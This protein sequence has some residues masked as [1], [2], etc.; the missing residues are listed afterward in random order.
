MSSLGYGLVTVPLQATVTVQ[1]E[2][3]RGFG[4]LGI[5]LFY[6]LAAVA[7][8]LFL[9][10]VFKQY[11]KYR[12][13]K[14]AAGR[15]S[16]LVPRLVGAL[17]TIASHATVRRT[18]GYAGFAH[19]LVFWGFVALLIGTA[20]VG[21]D[22]DAVQLAL[23]PDA[24]L[25]TGNVYLVFSSVM[26]LAG[27]AFIVGLVMM[28]VRRAGFG[29][30]KLDYA[31]VDLPEGAYD[32]S[33]Y[34]KGDALFL[35]LL[36]GIAITG[37]LIE[38]ARIA[39]DGPEFEV[40]SFVGWGI[41]QVGRSL[42]ASDAVFDAMWWVHVAAVFGFIAYLPHSKA[43]HMITD[44]ASLASTDEAA[45]IA[46]PKVEDVASP[47]VAAM[48]DFS[49]RQLLSFDACT[50]CG[51]CHEVCPARTSGAPL[52]P[53]DLILDLREKASRDFGVKEIFGISRPDE[54]EG[55]VAGGFIS[56][57]TLWSCTTCRACTD[58]CPV[59]VEHVVDIVQMR[60]SLIDKGAIPDSLGETL[61]S[62]D[63]K[64]NSFG[65]SGRKRPKW[66]KPLDFKVKDASKDEVDVLWFVGD[67]ASYNER[68]QD[69]TRSFAQVLENAGVDFGTL[70]KAEKS[71]GNDVRRV[72][73]EGLF[74]A[75][76]S[77]NIAALEKATFK[78]IVTTDPHTLN[79]LKH[80]YPAL[81][82]D[83]EVLHYSE[84]LLELIEAKKIELE[85]KTRRV[86][87][88]DP[89]YLGRYGGIFEVPRQVLEACG[90][91][92]VEMPRNREESFC[93]GAGG[94]R[95][96]MPDAES[97]KERPA[98][99]RIREAVELGVDTFVVACPKD[100]VMFSDA[101]KT[102]GNEG[103]IV[104]RDLIE[105]VAESAASPEKSEEKSDG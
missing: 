33:S 74:E 26:D 83:Y 60:R 14:D 18:D 93:C 68:C 89:C 72:G 59:G 99:N 64:G 104:V 17:S 48:T 53:R 10:G 88:H 95:I 32:R 12:R 30:P 35:W 27:L 51:R 84:L 61:R 49:W 4:G 16:P 24:K 31:R 5:G 45:G 58:I 54:S 3:F 37:F 46:L 2:V 38:G 55:V 85:A 56:A 52:S 7:S 82:A 34:K 11:R 41:A 87:Y 63:E 103:K 67:Y 79:T 43:M 23:G 78:R 98:E 75:L 39:A 21:V 25:L 96:W 90:S 29:L 102:S 65:E 77:D 76:A 86:T 13:G 40:A 71:A 81:G 66:S 69:S 8:G 22:E 50:K 20:I 97:V 100:N 42:L 70:G 105:F 94:G 1:R 80:E 19:M 6:G 101:V 9:F 62:L 91:E 28:L 92:I 36:L 73:E 44:V 15:L 57:E 47:G